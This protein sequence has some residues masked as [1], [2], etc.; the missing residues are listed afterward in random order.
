[1]RFKVEVHTFNK[2]L[3][4]NLMGRELLQGGEE[5][6]ITEEVR[7]RYERT[8]VRKVP[9]FP[10]IV[11][12]SIEIASNDEAKKVAEWFESVL[13]GMNVEKIVIDYI[14]V[15]LNPA[16]LTKAFSPKV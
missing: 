6:P 7:L 5:M 1:M 4:S 11:H 15:G 14:A 9:S 8:F 13:C 16:S 3:A 12:F 2:E 10:Q